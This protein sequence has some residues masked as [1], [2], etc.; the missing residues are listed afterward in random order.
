MVRS[1]AALIIAGNSNADHIAANSAN[2]CVFF[3]AI[4]E[5][6]SLDPLRCEV[7][8]TLWPKHIARY[9]YILSHPLFLCFLS[10]DPKFEVGFSF[11]ELYIS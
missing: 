11:L 8:G 7:V 1:P 10:D 9:M 2:V 3:A 6:H 5:M 4:D